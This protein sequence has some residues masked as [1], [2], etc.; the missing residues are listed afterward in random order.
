[1]ST[2]TPT[3]P[4]SGTTT[5]LADAGIEVL[6]DFHQDLFNERFQ[7][8]G[9]PD[10]AVQDD[11]LPAEPQLG[12]PYNYFAQLAL[13]RA[14]DHFWANAPG[15]GG[16][17]LQDRYAAAWAHVASYFQGTPGV[18]GFD[19]FNEPW[20]GTLW[21]RCVNPLGCP[22]FDARLQAFSQRTID[23][24][25]A[26]DQ[27]TPIFYEPHVLFNNGVRTTLT[28]TGPRLG[29]SFHDY[30]LTADVGLEGTPVQDLTCDVFDNL[31]WA[32][33]ERQLTRTGDTP[34]LT[35][36]GATTDTDVLE[37]MVD[38]AAQHRWGWQYWAYTGFDPTTSGPGA[39]Q[40]LVFDPTQ[41]P[42]GDNV[43]TAK[44]DRAGDAAPACSSR[45]RRPPGPSTGPPA[46]SPPPGRRPRSA[47]RA[48]SPPAPSPGSP[49][50]TS[51]TAPATAS[52]SPAARSSPPPTR[53]CSS[54]A[55]RLRHSRCVW[56]WRPADCD[57]A[58]PRSAA[59]ATAPGPGRTSMSAAC[60]GS[61]HLAQRRSTLLTSPHAWWR[62]S[63]GGPAP[64][65]SHLSPQPT[66]TIKTSKSSVPMVVRWYSKRGRLS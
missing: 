21:A 18:M 4:G 3:C 13:N 58:V 33:T 22:Q 24:I 59:Y 63:T 41:P 50:P 43:D 62:Y 16:V 30:C 45:A 34:L 2:T 32:N 17:G 60:I 66:M 40:A 27:R 39:E 25:R 38:R 6:L 49:C 28:P 61:P 19:L 64:P 55:R 35:E 37:S 47:H 65:A 44:L 5:V 8:E 20:P 53:P 1:M 48:G 54:Y 42:T 57:L 7:G 52:R 15:P 11:G 36:F 14:F 56:S 29:F 51:C 12:F 26:V 46:G 31:V 23:A 9:A 10:W